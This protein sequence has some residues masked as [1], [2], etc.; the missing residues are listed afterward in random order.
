MSNRKHTQISLAQ[1]PRP[2]RE[3]DRNSQTRTNSTTK[4]T[5]NTMPTLPSINAHQQIAI[6]TLPSITA[7]QQIVRSA[8]ESTTTPGR[9]SHTKAVVNV[10]DVSQVP[11]SAPQ[12]PSQPPPEPTYYGETHSLWKSATT[13]LKMMFR[14]T[15][16]CLNANP[17]NHHKPFFV[18][19]DCLDDLSSFL[20]DDEAL[21]REWY[22][23]AQPKWGGGGFRSD[24]QCPKCHG[25]GLYRTANY[26]M[27]PSADVDNWGFCPNHKCRYTF[28]ESC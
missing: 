4:S 1:L 9:S 6:P 22:K 28:F 18:P 20:W 10:V 11:V 16:Y 5:T 14:V 7:H 17:R 24:L 12:P 19:F 26:S 2:A 15:I 13:E 27:S 21:N 23:E 8:T 3:G 25:K